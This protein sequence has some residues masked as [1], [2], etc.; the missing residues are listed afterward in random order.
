MPLLSNALSPRSTGF[1][2]RA[3]Q[4]RKLGQQHLLEKSGISKKLFRISSGSFCCFSAQLA[5]SG[6][7]GYGERPAQKNTH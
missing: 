4:P 3:S 5:R 2:A 7:E 6:S 1:K